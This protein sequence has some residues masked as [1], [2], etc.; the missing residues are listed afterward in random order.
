MAPPVAIRTPRPTSPQSEPDEDSDSSWLFSASSSL[1]DLQEQEQ[2]QSHMVVAS[3]NVAGLS[4]TAHKWVGRRDGVL[5]STL[6]R[7]AMLHRVTPC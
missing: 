2:R 6:G 1:D 4:K 7:L 5:E 3:N